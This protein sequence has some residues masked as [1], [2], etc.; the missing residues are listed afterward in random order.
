MSLPT[1]I[2]WTEAQKDFLSD[3]T[4]RYKDI[5]DKYGVSLTAVKQRGVNE[6]W[7]EVRSDLSKKTIQQVE[8]KLIDR[9][10]EINERHGVA[11]R[12]LQQLAATKLTIAFRQVE[13]LIK[14]KGIDN[15]S[16]YDNKMIS[17]R[18]LKDLVEAYTGAINGE[19]IT[20]GLPTSIAR[21]EVTARNKTDLFIDDNY[22]D[23]LGLLAESLT[24]LGD[25]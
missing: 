12:N 1:K 5:S 10:S 18:D 23:Y 16:I 4:L 2:N 20:V 9:N 7:H 8:T 21:K 17:Q 14:E 11:F 6:H 19:R 22:E 15:I 3:P 25:K 13:R 24:A